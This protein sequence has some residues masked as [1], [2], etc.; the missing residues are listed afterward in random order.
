VTR[1]SPA[2][3]RHDPYW[4]LDGVGARRARDQRKSIKRIAM[5]VAIIVVTFLVTRLPPMDPAVL[6]SAEGK[7]LLAG[8]LMALLAASVLLGLARMRYANRR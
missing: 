4:D 3:D 6:T 7:P 1:L 5:L 8:A 2:P